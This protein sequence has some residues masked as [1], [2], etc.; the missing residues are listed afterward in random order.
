MTLV[1]H[2]LSRENMG[3]ELLAREVTLL[4][5]IKFFTIL[6]NIAE[7]IVLILSVDV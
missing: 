5:S 2:G 1:Y 7:N 4:G 3:L 6:L